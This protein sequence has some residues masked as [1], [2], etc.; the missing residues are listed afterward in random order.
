[1]ERYGEVLAST[2]F[3]LDRALNGL[4]HYDDDLRELGA[5][6]EGVP[7]RYS[8]RNHSSLLQ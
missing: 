7:S 4:W 5:R 2:E 6:R 1:M 8:P 3:L